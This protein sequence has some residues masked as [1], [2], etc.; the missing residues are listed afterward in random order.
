MAE[1]ST[2]AIKR[3]HRAQRGKLLLPLTCFM[4]R[5]CREILGV[6]TLVAAVHPEV[7]DFYRAILLF[8]DFTNWEIKTYEFVQG[9]AAI[10]GYLRIDELPKNYKK[11][12]GKKQPSRNLHAFFTETHFPQFIFPQREYRMAS[13]FNLSPRV[14][15][16]FFREH[17]DVFETLTTEE[18]KIISNCYFYS[19][20]RQVVGVEEGFSNRNHA[21][22]STSLPV[23]LRCE[24]EMTIH[25]GTAL[26]V[27]RKGLRIALPREVRTSLKSEVLLEIYLN[28]D[29][30]IP[31]MGEIVWIQPEYSQVG[32]QLDDWL[33]QTWLH[34]IDEF[35]SALLSAAQEKEN[36]QKK[37]G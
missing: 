28:E 30:R 23:R 32:I 8:Q 4:Y 29:L 24:N 20:Y 21:R 6:D 1:V 11:V 5:Y 31:L 7:I 18:K 35:E 2:L 9:A 19:I 33:P 37:F 3:G 14:M 15:Q 13:Q 12:Y 22:F 26:E 25:T 36:A 27:S 16:A 10:A 34:F 17:S